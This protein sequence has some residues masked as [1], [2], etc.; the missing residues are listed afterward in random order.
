M[1]GS[2][3][4]RFVSFADNNNQTWLLLLTPPTSPP[5]LPHIF[6]D[7]IKFGSDIT[8]FAKTEY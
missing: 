7:V 2:H 8:Y 3:D 6:F 1:N 5:L 4:V